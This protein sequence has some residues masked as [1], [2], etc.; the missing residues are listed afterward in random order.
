MTLLPWK[1]EYS[2]GVESV[3]SEHREMLE[4]LNE[5]YD[6]MTGRRDRDSIEQFLGDIHTA[7]SAHFALEEHLMRRSDYAGYE[8]HKDD[9][10]QLLDE[11]R[12]LMDTFFLDPDRGVERLQARLSRW[13]EGHFSTFDA[14]LHGKLATPS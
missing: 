13:F 9:H 5:L 6:E 1:S 14:R 7:I 11:I 3:D 12:D 2:V 4:L 10:E 8:A